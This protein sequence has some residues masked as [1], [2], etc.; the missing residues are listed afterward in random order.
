MG[1]TQVKLF[2]G[3]ALFGALAMVA[4]LGCQSIDGGAGGGATGG[5]QAPRIVVFER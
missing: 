4:P 2:A 3:A 1:K 5:G